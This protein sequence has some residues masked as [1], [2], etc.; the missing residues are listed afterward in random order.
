MHPNAASEIS[1]NTVE[2]KHDDAQDYPQS[3]ADIYS[4]PLNSQQSIWGTP[5]ESSKNDDNEITM[6]ETIKNE[7]NTIN[8]PI[9]KQ[10]VFKTPKS[11]PGY[12]KRFQIQEKDTIASPITSR[13]KKQSITNGSSG[14]M[15]PE[16]Q[17]ATSDHISQY[18][19]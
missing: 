17:A 13:L 3:E 2:I 5:P 8:T 6:S 9:A 19:R 1:T 4:T 14:K 15:L 11:A 12:K 10:I 18:H 16:V 7:S